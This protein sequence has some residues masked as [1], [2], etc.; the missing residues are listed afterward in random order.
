MDATR[1]VSIMLF[2]K[3]VGEE[4]RKI[5]KNYIFEQLQERFEK[6]VFSVPPDI[7][8]YSNR[9]PRFLMA[10]APASEAPAA[11]ENAENVENAAPVEDAEEL[12]EEVAEM[13]NPETENKASEKTES[14][15][16]PEATEASE[17][18]EAKP[19]EEK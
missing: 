19:S 10:D 5:I 16:N 6:L 17:S 13:E 2:S 1:L 12:N 9:N 18:S 8:D 7:E 14:T 3:Q 11:G 4:D 15:E